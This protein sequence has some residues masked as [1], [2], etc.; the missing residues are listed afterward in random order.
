M[1]DQSSWLISVKLLSDGFEEWE[2][3]NLN[4]AEAATEINGKCVMPAGM[5]PISGR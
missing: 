1:R 3:A 2:E 5:K 4:D